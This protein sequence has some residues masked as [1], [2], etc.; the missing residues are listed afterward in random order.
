MRGGF[1]DL[2]GPRRRYTVTDGVLGVSAEM[3]FM[4]R[5]LWRIEE[6]PSSVCWATRFAA[7]GK[8]A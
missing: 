1:Y 8:A 4:A 5:V 2:F 3:L 6:D 7:A